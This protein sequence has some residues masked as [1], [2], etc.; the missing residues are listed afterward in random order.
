MTGITSSLSMGSG[1]NPNQIREV[2]HNG[3]INK[4]T[5]AENRS[6]FILF[7]IIYMI[8]SYLTT[9]GISSGFTKVFNVGIDRIAFVAAVTDNPPVYSTSK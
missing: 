2:S 9:I 3:L 5:F 7:M 4:S 8:I 6:T 1:K